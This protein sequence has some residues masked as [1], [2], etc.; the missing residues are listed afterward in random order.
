MVFASEDIP[1]GDEIS[2]SYGQSFLTE[3]K[4]QRRDYLR[5]RYLFECH[6]RA[7]DGDFPTFDLIPKKL[8]KRVSERYTTLVDSVR[9]VLRD[10]RSDD[11]AEAMEKCKET[12]RVL[13]R[14]R[15]FRP[16]GSWETLLVL[17]DT[18]L[19]RIYHNN[20]ANPG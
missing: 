3:T 5:S 10:N 8:P 18:V 13:E 6:C 16:H 19:Q 7:C 9:S 2:D 12:F 14:G 11:L 1:K 4:C 15:I 20:R 17:T